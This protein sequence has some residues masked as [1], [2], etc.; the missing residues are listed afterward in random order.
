MKTYYLC[1][2]VNKKVIS[3]GPLPEVYGNINCLEGLTPEHL[4]DLGWAGSPGFGFLSY[5]DAQTAGMDQTSLDAAHD[6]A[7]TLVWDKIQAMRDYRK[8]NG[9]FP[10]GN[11]WF[12]SDESSRSQY[13]VYLG[14][15]LEEQIPN[16][17]VVRT[18]WK[19]M[20]GDLVDVT[21]GMMR[22][23]RDSG[24]QVENA[25]FDCAVAHKAN[26][27]ASDDPV[28]YDFSEGW[29]TTYLESIQK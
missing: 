24:I 28:S 18:G 10:V 6:I 11:Y 7:V 15:I 26:M 23:V 2:L 14:K 3:G 17:T 19:T 13:L 16:E 27:A 12:H 8:F 5:V 9:G 25:I 21:A 1:D 22:Q 20:S 4:A 29:P